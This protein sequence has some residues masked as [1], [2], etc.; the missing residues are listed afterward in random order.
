MQFRYL[1]RAILTKKVKKKRKY[2]K[3]SNFYITK[4][5]YYENWIF[6]FIINFSLLSQVIVQLVNALL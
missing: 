3:A 4:L 1:A 2:L 5:C 6:D